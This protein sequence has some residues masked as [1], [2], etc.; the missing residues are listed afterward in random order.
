MF[1]YELRLKQA[2]R[3]LRN[4]GTP[5]ER[6]LWEKL[7]KKQLGISFYRQKPVGEYVVDF[8]CPK[9]KLVIEIDGKYHLVNQVK[10]NDKSR[11]DIIKNLGLTVL[12]FSNRDII[13][14]VEN[15]LEKITNKIPL[16]PPLR[17]GETESRGIIL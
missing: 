3:E 10:E 13:T 6:I 2:A 14:N 7:R 8:Y 12:R 5:A 16:C 15:V 11:E 1:P 4:H 9:A 17:K